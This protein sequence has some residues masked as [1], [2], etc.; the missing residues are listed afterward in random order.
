MKCIFSE[1]IF[2][3][4]NVLPYDSSIFYDIENN[5]LK[6]KDKKNRKIDDKVE[7][8]DIKVFDKDLSTTKHQM[9]ELETKKSKVQ[10]NKERINALFKVNENQVEKK[11]WKK[12]GDKIIE[13]KNDSTEYLSQEINFEK[14]SIKK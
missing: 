13:D 9:K 14:F 11:K 10:A 3:I 1:H 12:N 7:S 4:Q 2:S 5:L 6:E 8:K